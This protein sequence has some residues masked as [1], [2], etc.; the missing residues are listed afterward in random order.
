MD[1]SAVILSL[2][3]IEVFYPS[4]ACSPISHIFIDAISHSGDPGNESMASS[5]FAIKPLV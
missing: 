3:L 2:P 1:P 5:C 4:L